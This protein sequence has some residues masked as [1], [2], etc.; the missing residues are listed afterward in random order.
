MDRKDKMFA[1]VELW[2]KSELSLTEFTVSHG[3][4][5]TTFAGWRKR[6]SK[7]RPENGKNS[8]SFVEITPQPNTVSNPVNPKIDIE[9]PGGIHIKIY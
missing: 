5:K 3:I 4:S 6:Y 9:L 1:L 8:L 7:E 2:N